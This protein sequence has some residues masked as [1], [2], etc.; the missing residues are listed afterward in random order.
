MKNKLNPNDLE[1]RLIEAA[2]RIIK[3]SEELPSNFAAQHLA[4]QLIK[5][6]TSAALI[7][8]EARAAESN[9]DFIHK[10]RICLKDLNESIICLKIIEKRGW[11]D[12]ARMNQIKA[13]NNELVAIFVVSI[14]T[15]KGRK[16]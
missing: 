14:N 5:S 4:K 6:T 9:K 7:Y 11:F 12:E 3:L 10:M 1:D 2:S 8:G 13:E 15:A 16:K